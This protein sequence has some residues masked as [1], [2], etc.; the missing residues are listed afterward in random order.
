[1]SNRRALWRSTVH[2]N[3]PRVTACRN[4]DGGEL[5][6][7]YLDS[8]AAT[9]DFLRRSIN[10]TTA[11]DVPCRCELLEVPPLGDLHRDRIGII[12]PMV[13]GMQPNGE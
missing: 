9:E 8:R 12:S 4:L 1:V 3:G 13:S 7:R 2:P 11:P 5:G 6:G 10:R